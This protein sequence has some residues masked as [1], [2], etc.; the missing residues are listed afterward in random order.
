ML[1]SAIEEALPHTAKNS[2]HTAP[3]VQ[4]TIT[5]TRATL[6]ESGRRPLVGESMVVRTSA[7]PSSVCVCP[8]MYD[9]PLIADVKAAFDPWAFSRNSTLAVDENEANPIWD[10]ESDV[11]TSNSE[12]MLATN[13]NTLP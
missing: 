9:T 13:G 2:H 3:R 11:P 4:L 10:C 1:H 6:A 5:R 7:S 12:L 8:R